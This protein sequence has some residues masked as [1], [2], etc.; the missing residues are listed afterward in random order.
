MGDFF[1]APLGAQ[2]QSP[3]QRPRSLNSEFPGTVRLSGPSWELEAV[4]PGPW[5]LSLPGGPSAGLCRIVSASWGCRGGGA[6]PSPWLL[7]R[8]V[9]TL[10]RRAGNPPE[11]LL[12]EF[13]VLSGQ[14]QLP[15]LSKHSS[16]ET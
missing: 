7:L 5:R 13:A 9:P 12:Q 3:V 6:H 8:E 10:P 1:F 4:A 11:R 16:E 15:G 2:T 14:V